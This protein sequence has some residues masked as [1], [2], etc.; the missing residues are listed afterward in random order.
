M[1]IKLTAMLLENVP[2][3]CFFRLSVYY[4]RMFSKPKFSVFHSKKISVPFSIATHGSIMP[5]TYSQGKP[6]PFLLLRKVMK[7]LW[8]KMK[9]LNFWCQFQGKGHLWIQQYFH[10]EPN[11]HSVFYSTAPLTY[12]HRVFS[13]TKLLFN[14]QVLPFLNIK[15]ESLLI[16]VNI[17]FN[18]FLKEM[19]ITG[20]RGSGLEFQVFMKRVQLMA[21]PS[22]GLLKS[23]FFNSS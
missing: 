11:S 14:K 4:S 16:L 8:S 20:S 23:L 17:I 12:Q 10:E 21:L 6:M 2:L 22:S 7:F 9:F 18:S 19:S 13:R 1:K 3:K 15:S 5:I